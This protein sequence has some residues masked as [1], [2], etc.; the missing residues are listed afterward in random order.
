MSKPARGILMTLSVFITLLVVSP[1]HRAMAATVEAS[2][3]V[4][5]I[6]QSVKVVEQ[7]AQVK[8]LV[9]SGDTLSGIHSRVCGNGN[10]Q[11]T[12]AENPFIS[13]PN[14]IYP[15]QSLTL[16][17]VAVTTPQAP[18]AAPAPQQTSTGW[19]QPVS[20]CN[21]SGFGMRWGQ[22]HNGV[23]LAAGY[24]TP[25]HAAAAGTLSTAYQAGGAGNYTMINHGGGVWT[26]Y[27]HQSSFAVQSGHVDAGQVI[28]YVGQTGDAQ[29]PHLHF[30]VHT[31][32]LWN[33]RVDPMAFMANHGAALC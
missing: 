16:S 26:V 11:A 30:E 20:A 28:G 13:N 12:W 18:A 33:G 14:L 27:M 7:V 19:T 21:I 9:V 17:C 4:V 29:G 3:P 32:G 1:T 6:V 8:V 5:V 23:D 10:W 22:M 15:G 31:G 25:I 24:G 2:P